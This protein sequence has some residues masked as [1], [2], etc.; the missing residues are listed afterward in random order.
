MSA[1]LAAEALKLRTTRLSWIVAGIAAILSGLIGYAVVQIAADQGE[2]VSLSA[3]AA[4]PAQAMWFLGIVVALV[5]SAG[6]FQHR[7]I[8]TTLLASPR[9]IP[10]LI[11]K[12]VVAAAYGALLVVLGGTIAAVAAWVTSTLL[13]ESLGGSSVVSWPNVLGTVVVGA[14][15][16]IL[17]TGLGI[18][19]RSIAVAVGVVL[20]WRFVGEGVLPVVTG[21]DGI[22]RWLP[23][24]LAQSIV[25]GT[26]PLGAG[27]VLAGYVA[28]ISGL[29]AVV[30]LRRDPT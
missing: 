1:L 9:R 26:A 18:L 12:S 6:E 29:G 7:T 11:A 5:A 21:V 15:W 19:T 10:V 2:P 27:V 13:H 16:P 23:M 28:A 14:L 3:V 8:R 25:E 20:L 17:A 24:G 4:A 22:S 30:F